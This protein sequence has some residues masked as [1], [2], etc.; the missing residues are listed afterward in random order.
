MKRPP[1]AGTWLP[2]ATSERIV[3]FLTNFRI[4]IIIMNKISQLTV[5]VFLLILASTSCIKENDCND[6][7]IRIGVMIPLTGAGS[8]QGESIS[9][10]LGYASED[11]GRY[12]T[13]INSGYGI[14]MVVEDTESDPEVAIRKYHDLKNKGI[15][16]I[17]GPALSTVLSAVKPFADADGILLVSPGSVATSLSVAGDNVYR[18]VP[19]FRDHTGALAALIVADNIEVIIPVV[20]NDLWGNDLLGFLT[21]HL[22][23]SGK[24]V[25]EAVKYGS[26]S[27]DFS[28]VVDQLAGKVE[29]ALKVHEPD[30]IG[31][32]MA[33]YGEGTDLLRL[34]SSKKALNLVRWYGS[35]VFAEHK[36]LIADKT[37]ASFAVSVKLSCPAYGFDPN[38]RSKW[39]PF[40]K[41]LENDL[42]RKPEVYSI[43]AYDAFWLV[44]LTYLT[45]GDNSDIQ[46]LKESFVTLANNYYGVTGWTRL[47]EAGD[48]TS[49]MY[50]FW[51]IKQTNEDPARYEWNVVARFNHATGVLERIRR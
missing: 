30:Q 29:E 31:V 37:A 46:S 34:A 41:K 9:M 49:G 6:K 40:V 17:V 23:N 5:L 13:G 36:S 12:L 25:T 35:T 15:K 26:G 43:L 32:L 22:I 50:D 33:S 20:F 14:D 18:L 51:G 10:S 42:G 38:A 48:R 21:Y 3:K 47:N 28:N 1:T 45:T 2:H 27:Q 44:A 24:E 7:T 11:V 16:I 4:K 39:E 8:S 19:D